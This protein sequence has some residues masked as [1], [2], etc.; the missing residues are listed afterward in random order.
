MDFLSDLELDSLINKIYPTIHGRYINNVYSLD[1]LR[2]SLT[3]KDSEYALNFHLKIGIWLSDKY[4]KERWEG[5]FIRKLRDFLEGSRLEGAEVPR[6]Q[7]IIALRVSSGTLYM[8]LFGGSNLICTDR[9]GI[10]ECALREAEF[11]D[12]KVITGEVYSLPKLR[13]TPISEIFEPP[14]NE[15]VP[16]SKHLGF[17]LATSKKFIDEILYRAGVQ[18]DK[19]ADTL[20]E[21]EKGAIRKELKGLVEECRNSEL[22]YQY[23]DGTFSLVK[24]LSKG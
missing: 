5:E 15:K 21:E 8:E 4:I 18:P 20:S 9:S 3:V 10:V 2:Y 1:E 12:R 24:L 11:K 7:R 16:I 14:Y 13:G 23:Q 22:M 17:Y 19:I 6:G